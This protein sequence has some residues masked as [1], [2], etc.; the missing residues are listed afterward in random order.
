MEQT[1]FQSRMGMAC[2][3]RQVF[4]Y[5]DTCTLRIRTRLTTSM[6]AV[7]GWR[8]IAPLFVIANGVKGPLSMAIGSN[9]E[10]IIR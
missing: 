9:N 7:G 6:P 8:E 4:E 2:H 1:C 3:C 10:T 5:M